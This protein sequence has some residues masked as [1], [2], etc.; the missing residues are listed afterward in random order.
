MDIRLRHIYDKL[1]KYSPR[2]YTKSGGDEIILDIELLALDTGKCKENIVYIGKSSILK[3]INKQELINGVFIIYVDEEYDLEWFLENDISILEICDSNDLKDIFNEIKEVFLKNY[4]LL[5]SSS[6]LL[7]ALFNDR[8][9]NNIVNI[10]SEILHNPVIFL[11]VG[12]RILAHS[13]SENIT[14]PFWVR[15]INM[16]YCSYEFISSVFKIKTIQRAPDTIEPFI[17][18]CKESPIRKLVSKVIINDSLVGYIILLESEEKFTESTLQFIK[19][20][21]NVVSE[22]LKKNKIYRNLRGLMYENLIIDILEKNVI[23]EKALKKRMKSIECNFGNDMCL[24]LIDIS[25]Y[26]Y[27]NNE[28]NF[29]RRK[30][31]EVFPRYKSFFYKEHV[32]ILAEETREEIKKKVSKEKINEFLNYNDIIM[33]I[34]NNFT[35]V[36][37]LIAVYNQT[38]DTLNL[39][40]LLNLDGNLFFYEDFKFYNMLNNLYNQL[41]LSYYCNDGVLKLIQ[42][43]RENDTEYYTTLKT[44]IKEDKNA[45]IASEKL[46]IHRNTMNY[47]L[48]KIKDISKI[49]LKNH[50]DIFFIELSIRILDFLER[51][52]ETRKVNVP[53]VD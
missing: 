30:I 44:Y 40:R 52:G 20:L 42:Y 12:Y 7:N 17:V 26:A 38:L 11:D 2:L 45:I 53:N 18:V 43:D 51:V 41:D 50:N 15:N 33:I 10:S 3:F 16:G 36:L 46:F 6:T 21:N 4:M 37:N 19:L 5:N 8:G 39:V 28:T 25:N 29:L 27:F 31:D 13:N 1:S 24:F 9:L 32:L 47:R 23:D 48:N 22:E 49:D 35:S 34:S 14:E